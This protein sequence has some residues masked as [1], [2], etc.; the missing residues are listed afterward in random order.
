[1]YGRINK[2]FPHG[3][4]VEGL[5]VEESADVSG[6]GRSKLFELIAQGALPARKVG[7][8]TII[9]RGELMTFLENLPRAGA[10]EAA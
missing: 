10:G 1:M 7:K 6:I 4:M 9:L 3:L 8:K 5:S 2:L